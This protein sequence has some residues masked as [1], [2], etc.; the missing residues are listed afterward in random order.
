MSKVKSHVIRLQKASNSARK[1]SLAFKT[2]QQQR[3]CPSLA[4]HMHN[5]FNGTKMKGCVCVCLLV[6]CRLL[7]SCTGYGAVYERY[8][9]QVPGPT[10]SIAQ[11]QYLLAICAEGFS[12]NSVPFIFLGKGSGG[13]LVKS[14]CPALP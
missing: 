6:I 1:P 14:F 8:Q 11:Q 12:C 3:F 4:I 10:I 7:F 5:R 2:R 9:Q 13:I